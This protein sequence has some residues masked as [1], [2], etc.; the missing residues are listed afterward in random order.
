MNL[1]GLSYAIFGWFFAKHVSKVMA[2]FVCTLSGLISTWLLISPYN[3]QD[4]VYQFITNILLS[5]LNLIIYLA[6]VLGVGL[7]ILNEYS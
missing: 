7:L 6:L 3:E 2:L 1:T 4:L 5:D